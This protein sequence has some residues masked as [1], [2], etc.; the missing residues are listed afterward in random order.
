MKKGSQL[1]YFQYCSAVRCMILF[2]SF[3]AFYNKPVQASEL[4]ASKKCD[5]NT[6]IEIEKKHLAITTYTTAHGHELNTHKL[7]NPVIYSN[8]NLIDKVEAISSLDIALFTKNSSNDFEIAD[9][10]KIN[11]D[12]N[13]NNGIDNNDVLKTPSPQNSLG[14]LKFGQELSIENRKRLQVTDSIFL[15]LSGMQQ[16][17]YYFKMLPTQL[18]IGNL[19]AFLK[20]NYTQT[21]TTVSSVDLTNINFTI[22]NDAASLAPNRF[23]I[24]FRPYI[25]AGS[26]PV[27]FLSMQ[28]FAN[29]NKTNT[30]LWKVAIEL[31]LRH[32]E[33]E[34]STNGRFFSKFGSN[35]FSVGNGNAANYSQIDVTPPNG[36]VYYRIRAVSITGQSVY[37]N[38][39]KL[40]VA[41]KNNAIQI[42]PNPVV[43]KT[44]QLKFNDKPGKYNYT[45]INTNGQ[46][47]A[48]GNLAVGKNFVE[49]VI[50]LNPATQS[51]TF[52]IVLLKDEIDK[53]AIK[54]FIQ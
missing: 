7:V 54:F 1:L 26:L 20:D 38:I 53:K 21:E 29:E 27:T 2:F 14:I 43:N 23:Y 40:N 39:I 10:V 47:V 15:N 42:Y 24:F 44:V 41:D 31:N 12:D 32:Y 49:K 34:A 28:G 25:V 9:S 35:V 30:I 33:T 19:Q 8:K 36:I 5:T 13:Y 52:T 22:T 37:S 11:F 4:L 51:G 6:I 3:F 16:G 46:V 17:A 45:I 48:T 50:M 18:G